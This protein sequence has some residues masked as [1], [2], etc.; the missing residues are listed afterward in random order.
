[1]HPKQN[2]FE[3]NGASDYQGSNN[4]DN[5]RVKFKHRLSAPSPTELDT[6]KPVKRKV[7]ESNF[8]Y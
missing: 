6:C 1:M 5:L 7:S 3:S 8:F 4:S 2:S